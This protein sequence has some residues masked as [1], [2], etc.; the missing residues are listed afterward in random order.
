MGS[1]LHHPRIVQVMGVCKDGD[2]WLLVTELME[3]RSLHD[4]LHNPNLRSAVTSSVCVSV[5][6]SHLIYL[7]CA[8]ANVCM[9][10]LIYLSKQW[11]V[12]FSCR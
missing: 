2:N 7:I 12:V 10:Y 1:G 11:R 5:F 4:C 3:N 8:Y 6:V 9:I